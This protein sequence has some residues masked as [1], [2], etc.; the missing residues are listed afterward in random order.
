VDRAQGE[1]EQILR[2]AGFE[3]EFNYPLG[4]ALIDRVV[5]QSDDPGTMLPRGSTI[6]LQ[7]V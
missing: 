2:D 1:A 6:T 4:A 7:I 5:G 3:V